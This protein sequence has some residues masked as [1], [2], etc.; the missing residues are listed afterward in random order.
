MRNSPRAHM[1]APWF[2][3]DDSFSAR[4]L[5][6]ALT[7][8]VG[9]YYAG[10]W[11]RQKLTRPAIANLPVICVGN[12]NVGGVGKTP[13]C[14]LIA[15]L[16]KDV[17]VT[18]AFLSRGYGGALQGPIKVDPATHD[19]TQT[20][21]EPLLLA[22]SAAT[23]V[24]KSKPSG[25][26]A[27]GTSA[28]VIIMDDGFQNPTLKKDVSLLLSRAKTDPNTA[29]L[30]PAGP[31]REPWRDA[32]ARADALVLTDLA[33]EAPLPTWA[34]LFNGPVFRTEIKTEAHGEDKPAIAF[35]G[36]GNPARFFDL[37]RAQGFSLVEALSF[38][39]HHHFS[40]AE[41]SHLTSLARTKSVALLTTEKDWMRL[42][43]DMQ[44]QV[45]TLPIHMSVDKPD[46]L[47]ALLLETTIAKPKMSAS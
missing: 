31:M 20:G 33:K 47:R 4:A 32:V 6:A 11:L 37:A 8:A 21:D 27:I 43:P 18:P 1:D 36:I 38:P 5:R 14:R 40:A 2:W 44:Q 12:A 24:A 34:E 25:A 45:K 13:F 15:Q 17:G 3:H 28:D 19:F 29:S 22:K 42:P 16:L 10:Y 23:W 39:D 46:A 35:C 41:L 9:A 26:M 7:P 30:L